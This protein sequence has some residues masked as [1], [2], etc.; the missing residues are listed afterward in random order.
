MNISV[1]DAGI[2]LLE[3][4]D[5]LI[6]GGEDVVFIAE[7]GKPI[8]KLT[9]VKKAQNKRLGVAKKEMENFDLSLEEFNNITTEEFYEN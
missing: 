3:L 9:L 7:N 5:Q 6:N 2:F 4:I 8:A 1:Q